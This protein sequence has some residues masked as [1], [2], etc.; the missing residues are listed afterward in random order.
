MMVIGSGREGAAATPAATSKKPAVEIANSKTFTFKWD[1]PSFPGTIVAGTFQEY[2]SDDAGI[3]LHLFFKPNKESLS[4]EYA[5]TAVK[6][7]TYFVTQYGVAPSS[8]L[9]LVKL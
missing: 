6:E 8:R 1:K 4:A 7:F 2:K 5:S 3:D 9:N